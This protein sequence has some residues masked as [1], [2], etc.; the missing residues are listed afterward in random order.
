MRLQGPRLPGIIV[1]AAGIGLAIALPFAMIGCGS[2][3][4]SGPAIPGSGVDLQSQSLGDPVV[5]AG[6]EAQSMGVP[7]KFTLSISKSSYAQGEPVELKVSVTNVGTAPIQ[8]SPSTPRFDTLVSAGSNSVWQ[9][10]KIYTNTLGDGAVGG[11]FV[12]NNGVYTPIDTSLMP[13]ATESETTDWNQKDLQ[14]QFV[15]PG[16]YSIR[17]WMTG[18]GPQAPVSIGVGAQ[19]LQFTPAQ[20]QAVLTPGAIT[21]TVQEGPTPPGPPPPGDLT[22]SGGPGNVHL[23][24]SAVANVFGYNVSR[25][26]TPGSHPTRVNGS[27]PFS[28]DLIDSSVTPGVT[29]YYVVKSF[30]QNFTEGAASREVW[31]VPQPLP[32][33][34][35]LPPGAPF[36]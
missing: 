5:S 32:P 27:D 22:A 25:G 16:Q 3:D 21:I 7:L 36:R 24:W 30:D 1:C 9:Y 18:L 10:S 12:D 6:T 31:A 4:S 26:T 14:Y 13:G 29:Y 15:P 8:F 23:S 20:A 17:T 35:G 19:T 2:G 28:T 34:T 11:G 33:H